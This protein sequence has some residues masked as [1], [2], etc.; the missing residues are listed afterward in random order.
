MT[1]LP[2]RV[3]GV[4]A[5]AAIAF[6]FAS[7][8]L[9]SPASADEHTT[10]EACA[11]VDHR[12]TRTPPSPSTILLAVSTNLDAGTELIVELEIDGSV[13]EGFG[14]ADDSGRV[15]LLVPIYTFGNYEVVSVTALTL[16]GRRLTFPANAFGTTTIAIGSNEIACDAQQLAPIAVDDPTPTPTGAPTSAPTSASTTAPT[17]APASAPSPAATTAPTSTGTETAVLPP[18]G[19]GSGSDFPFVLTTLIGAGLVITLSGAGLLFSG[20]TRPTAPATPRPP[21][22]GSPSSGRQP[23]TVITAE[24]SEVIRGIYDG[25]DAEGV[26]I[27]GLSRIVETSDTLIGSKDSPGVHLGQ[28]VEIQVALDPDGKPIPRIEDRDEFQPAGSLMI[29]RV[30]PHQEHG[31]RFW[32]ADVQVWDVETARLEYGRSSGPTT[33]ERNGLI[34]GRSPVEYGNDPEFHEAILELEAGSVDE[35][36]SQALRGAASGGNVVPPPR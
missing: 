3:S 30:S 1:T 23:P 12:G 14:F 32:R 4:V 17:E 2:R 6:S 16:D 13:I 20:G 5:F 22:P 28:T 21:A 33:E 26:R 35:A 31:G 11:G 36:V 25:A 29:I 27:A 18:A 8:A 24:A 9:P 7:I 15:G 19:T 10:G 34:D